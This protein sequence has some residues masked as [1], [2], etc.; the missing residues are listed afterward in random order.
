MRRFALLVLL[1][2]LLGAC[3]N[4]ASVETAIPPGSEVVEPRLLGTWE[5]RMDTALGSRIIITQES[6][7]QYMIRD[8]EVDG[9]PSVFMGRLG[10][11]GA[12]RLI[13][14]LSP[15]ADTTKMF[16]SMS[17]DSTRL[18][19]P[20]YPLM[21]AIHMSF[22]IERADSGLVF[23]AFNGDTLLADLTAGHLRTP[24]VTAKQG[25]IAATVLL[26]EQDPQKLNAALQ[27]FAD[28]P[29]ALL[30]L[31]RVGRRIAFPIRR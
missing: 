1:T 10:P 16:H 13:L 31:A 18:N 7:T 3:V 21:L 8:L 14:E 22:V 26:T 11:L 30:V 23:E 6:A 9:S 4:V 25:D 15:V 24:F 5:V 17:G 2:P 27:S 20:S 12:H 19:P 29:G 28:R